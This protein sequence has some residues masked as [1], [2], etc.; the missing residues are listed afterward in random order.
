[1]KI[2]P[3]IAAELTEAF[4]QANFSREKRHVRRLH[5][6]SLIEREGLEGKL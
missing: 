3:A 4:C 2:G 5:A 6:V 1:M